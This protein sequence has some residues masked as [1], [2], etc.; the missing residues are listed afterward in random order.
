MISY[1]TTPEREIRTEIG[2]IAS[3]I[4]DSDDNINWNTIE[5]FGE[6]WRKFDSFSEGEIEKIG[7]D[8]FDIVSKN[9][10]NDETY[11]LD[12]AC[13]SGRWSYYMA[14]KAKFIEAVDPSNAI[15]ISQ[16]MLKNFENIRVTKASVTSLPFPD[17]SF[18]LVIRLGVLHHIPE[19][20]NALKKCVKKV[21]K[22]GACLIHLCY[23]LDNRGAMFKI[24]FKI[25]NVFRFLISKLPGVIKRLVCDII[26]FTIYLPLSRFNLLIRSIGLQSLADKLPLSYYRDK[27]LNVLRNDSL[28]RFGTPLEQRFSKS[29]I[30]E[31]M[32]NSG[33]E[34]IKFSKNEPY[35]HA[36]GIK[37]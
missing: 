29:E 26:A 33:L 12:M 21:K 6:E 16:K 19:T 17:N 18:D 27:S 10:L 24:I 2:T 14:Q 22:R 31:M 37:K 5:S 1:S 15:L 9:Y 11:V 32:K 34:E 7:N 20:N 35:W 3:F 13:G 28:D 23:N 30:E 8:Y 36:I 25:A 4:K